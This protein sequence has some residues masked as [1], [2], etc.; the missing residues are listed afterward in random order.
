VFNIYLVLRHTKDVTKYGFL[1]GKWES[2]FIG[3]GW[4]GVLSLNYYLYLH[5]IGED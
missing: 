3:L 5:F 4:V 1:I 2:G